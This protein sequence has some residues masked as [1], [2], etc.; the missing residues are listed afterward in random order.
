[1]ID[2]IFLLSFYFE[3]KLDVLCFLNQNF[4]I[5]FIKSF[6]T[7]ILLRTLHNNESGMLLNSRFKFVI[8]ISS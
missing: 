3:Y 2:K 1:M 7:I 4:K 5:R 8:L 6:V